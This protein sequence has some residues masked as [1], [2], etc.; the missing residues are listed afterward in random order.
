[1]K[2][3]GERGKSG[4]RGWLETAVTFMQG[5][6][7]LLRYLLVA[8]LATIALVVSVAG[9]VAGNVKPVTGVLGGLLSGGGEEGSKKPLQPLFNLEI[10]PAYKDCPPRN[11][12]Q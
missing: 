7:K 9:A 4:G 12:P 5:L 8:V 6:S 2:K 10:K 11:P 1:M 3:E